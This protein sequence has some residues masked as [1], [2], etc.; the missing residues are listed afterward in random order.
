MIVE[1]LVRRPTVLA[2]LGAPGLR[3][4][5]LRELPALDIAILAY[6]GVAAT[7]GAYL[8]FVIGMHLSRTAA[9]RLAATLIEPGVGALL[10]MAFS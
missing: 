7:G 10:A 8:A 3:F 1:D 6:T 4:G 2:A 5:G 9:S